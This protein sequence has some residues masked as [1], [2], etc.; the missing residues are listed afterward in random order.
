MKKI[1]G[2]RKK[3]IEFKDGKPPMYVCVPIKCQKC[4]GTGKVKRR[5]DGEPS[6]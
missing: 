6:Q 1:A 2:K 5:P 3:K 4:K